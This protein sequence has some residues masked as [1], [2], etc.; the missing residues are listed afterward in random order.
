MKRV[1]LLFVCLI[2]AGALLFGS[3]GQ[4]NLVLDQET[5]DAGEVLRKGEPIMHAFRIKN[6]GTGELKILSVNPG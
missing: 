1:A 3:D 4:P 2:F 6:T 5:Y